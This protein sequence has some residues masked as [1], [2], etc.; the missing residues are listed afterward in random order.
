MK[1]NSA[2][3]ISY[4]SSYFGYRYLDGRDVKMLAAHYRTQL[5]PPT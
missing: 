1:G 4:H 3:A 5:I 2:H